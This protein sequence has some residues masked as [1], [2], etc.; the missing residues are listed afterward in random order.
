MTK[1]SHPRTGYNQ[2]WRTDAYDSLLTLARLFENPRI[3]TGTGYRTADKSVR[4]CTQCGRQKKRVE[5][6]KN[7]WRKGYGASKC[8]D[9]ITGGKEQ[10][11]GTEFHL[12]GFSGLCVGGWSTSIPNNGNSVSDNTSIA[13]AQAQVNREYITCDAADCEAIAPAIRCDCCEMA[14][15]CS[16]ACQNRH[17]YE[18]APDCRSIDQ[19]RDLFAN[20]EE[21]NRDSMRGWAMATQLS[22]KRTFDALLAQAECIHQ[23]DGD[24][25]IAIELYK[26]LLMRDQ[27]SATPPQFRQVWMGLSRCFYEM[28]VYE[29][30]IHSGMA[31][32]EMNRHFPQAHKY[33]ALAQR[34]SGDYDAAIAT[35]TRAVLYEAPWEDKNLESN[36]ALLKQVVG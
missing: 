21:P 33:V 34:A 4:G 27:D 20:Q 5:F 31:A 2:L 11:T 22:G 7:Q 19:M 1:I 16:Q 15:Y 18:H 25:E 8:H 14:Y 17:G 28:G 36:R 26:E 29:L 30:A 32:L 6:S 9:C 3:H 12:S 10:S 13:Q 24:W 35:M 23:V